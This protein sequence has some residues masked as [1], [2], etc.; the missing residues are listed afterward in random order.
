MARS[1][2]KKRRFKPGRYILLLLV[3]CAVVYSMNSTPGA[4][5]VRGSLSDL[6]GTARAQVLLPPS[7][8][9]QQRIEQTHVANEVSTGE[10]PKSFSLMDQIAALEAIDITAIKR[11]ELHR[12]A[13]GYAFDTCLVFVN[14]N[15]FAVRIVDSDLDATMVLGESG[16]IRLGAIRIRDI[17]LAKAVEEAPSETNVDVQ[18]IHGRALDDLQGLISYDAAAQQGAVLQ[19]P[20][21]VRG[22]LSV[23]ISLLGGLTIDRTISMDFEYQPDIS[24]ELLAA[25]RQSVR[26][27]WSKGTAKG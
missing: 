7:P 4:E 17:L 8:P 14:A 10:A 22:T 23:E 3:V 19:V 11:L 16:G 26:T 9:V 21:R 6:D 15:P 25:F 18:V 24:A 2:R 1:Y 27:A 12:Q 20:L 13:D 5:S